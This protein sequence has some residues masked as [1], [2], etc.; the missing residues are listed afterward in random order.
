MA[1]LALLAI[2]PWG[3]SACASPPASW[4]LAIAPGTAYNVPLA[5]RI[6]QDGERPLRMT[7]RYATRPLHASPYYSA[8]LARG[9]QRGAWEAEIIHHKLHLRNTTPEVSGLEATHGYN[10]LLVN[11]SKR[12]GS[13]RWRIGIGVVLLHLEGSVRAQ[14]VRMRG[15]FL[16]SGYRLTGPSAQVAV[17]RP[18]AAGRRLFLSP[19]VK[20]TAARAVAPIEGGRVTIPNVALHGLVGVGYRF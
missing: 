15:G 11:R 4:T 2:G 19:E 7:A 13:L 12:Y 6:E 1:W 14:A 17:G 18:I 16:G 10:Y 3:A 20:L 5:L 9:S 8:R